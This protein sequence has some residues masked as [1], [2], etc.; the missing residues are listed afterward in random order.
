[1]SWKLTHH[2]DETFE[3]NMLAS[4]IL[5]LRFRPILKVE[6]RLADFQDKVRTRF[7]G[8]NTFDSQEITVGSVKTSA[9]QINVRNEKVHQFISLDE[10]SVMTLSTSALSVEYGHHRS[11]E[12][13]FSDAALLLEALN[14]VYAPVIP[15]RLGLRYVNLIQLSILK[16]A[17][18]RDVTWPEVL[19]AKFA[20]VP[21][22]GASLNGGTRFIAEVSSPCER[23]NMTLR[24]GLLSNGPEE[25]PHFRL[26]VDRYLEG[27][28]SLEEIPLLLK[29]F[30]SNIFC[31]FMTAAGPALLE[32][33]RRPEGGRV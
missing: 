19:S 2:P 27:V 8:F 32:W 1:V 25:E 22:G 5:Q 12:T 21:G 4:V 14:A 13:V 30:S 15:A 28:F 29:T 24:H 3:Q 16:K 17:L 23:G 18:E 33:M 10:S 20:E 9:Q 7:P 6:T 26:D 31:M 11:K